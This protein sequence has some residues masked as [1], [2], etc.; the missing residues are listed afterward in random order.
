[1]IER[2]N[3]DFDKLIEIIKEVAREQGY[4]MTNG[5][6]KFQVYIDKYHAVAFEVW[7]NASSGYIQIHQ[8]EGG[9]TESAGNYGRGVYS[10]RSYSDV[11]QFCNIMMSSAAIRARRR[12]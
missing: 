4:E 10:L 2:E 8:W 11:V 7:A 6:R 1:M 3:M 12:A 5:D 9:E